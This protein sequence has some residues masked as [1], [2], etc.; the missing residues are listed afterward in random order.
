MKRCAVL[1]HGSVSG[2]PETRKLLILSPEASDALRAAMQDMTIALGEVRQLIATDK[3]AE[4][5]RRL[6]MGAHQAAS[7]LAASLQDAKPAEVYSG[8]QRVVAGCA[9]CEAAYRVR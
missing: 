4:A 9:A 1:A 5:A 7:A 6:G 8:L 3:R 2:A